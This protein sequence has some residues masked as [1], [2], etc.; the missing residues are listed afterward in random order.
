ML[1]SV[2]FFMEINNKTTDQNFL[3]DTKEQ[4]HRDVEQCWFF[5]EIDENKTMDKNFLIDSQEYDLNT[6]DEIYSND[7]KI[8]DPGD[9][10]DE[11]LLT[12]S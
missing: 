5:I 3:I 4:I 2:C 7:E 1:S 9:I 6:F 10:P 11:S 12:D 8:F